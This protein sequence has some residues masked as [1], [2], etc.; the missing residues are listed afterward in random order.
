[1]WIGEISLCSM[2]QGLELSYENLVVVFVIVYSLGRDQCCDVSLVRGRL[3][4]YLSHPDIK[5]RLI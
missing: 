1:M 4:F 3:V 2:N 5:Y